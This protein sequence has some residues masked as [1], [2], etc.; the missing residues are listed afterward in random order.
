MIKTFPYGFYETFPSVVGRGYPRPTNSVGREMQ[1]FCSIYTIPPVLRATSPKLL[2][3][4][5]G[6]SDHVTLD[7]ASA[8]TEGLI[9]F[10]QDADGR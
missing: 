6:G 7:R 4:L 8:P 2:G 3:R 10:T 5:C 9:N 1:A